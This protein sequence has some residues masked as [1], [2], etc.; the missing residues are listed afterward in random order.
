[1]TDTL[2]TDAVGSAYFLDFETGAERRATFAVIVA[3]EPG[4]L[5]RVV[6]LFSARGYNI[7]SLTVAETDHAV[8]TSRITIVTRGR[9]GVLAQI[10]AQLGKIVQVRQVFEVGGDPRWVER[11]LALVKVRGTGEHRVEALRIAEI[12]RARVID[13]GTDSF[14]FELTGAPDKIDKFETLMRP[15]GLVEVSRTGVLSIARG[16]ERV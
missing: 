15:L 5:A 14:V 9:E 2:P 8:H 12:F 13:T 1:M 4:V 10:K 6:G 3:N 16:A 7:E 11:E